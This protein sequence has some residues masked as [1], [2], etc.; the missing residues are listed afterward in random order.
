MRLHV[1]EFEDQAWFPSTIR[2]AMMDYLQFVFDKINIYKPAT[3]ILTKMMDRL[4]AH[5]IMDLCSGSG[6]DMLILHKQLETNSNQ[7]ILISLSDKFP[8]TEVYKVIEHKSNG[9]ITYIG[10]S[11][12]ATDYVSEHKSIRTIFSAFHHFKPEYAQ[13]VLENAIQSNAPIAIFDGGTKHLLFFLSMLIVHPLALFIVTPFIRPFSLSRLFF[14]YIIPLI[15]LCTMWDGSI[16]ILRLY[17]TKDMEK[18]I[19]K[20]GIGNYYWEVGSKKTCFG[21][22]M[23][24]LIGIPNAKNSDNT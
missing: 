11:V 16:S 22:K 20:S 3:L 18:I 8:N 17:T 19:Y 15:P 2:N 5:Q 24:Y 7:E 21:L 9:H 12:E 1:F 6:G 23:N 13:K 10:K 14:T 4:N